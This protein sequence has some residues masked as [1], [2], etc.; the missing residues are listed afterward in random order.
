MPFSLAALFQANRTSEGVSSF[1]IYALRAVYALM[2]F[3]LGQTVWTHILAHHGPWEPDNAMAWSVWAAFSALAG[4]GI[5]RPLRM[6]PILL[7]EIVYKSLWLLLVAYPLW[8]QG[9]LAGSA[10]EYQATV[11]AGVILPIVA[12]PWRYVLAEFVY[13]A[14]S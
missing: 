9:R 5:L 10:V 2:F 12:V 6:L 1:N 13:R 7:L 3:M 8:A 11:F 4:L 14:K